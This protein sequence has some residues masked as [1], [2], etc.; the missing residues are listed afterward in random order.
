MRIGI[1]GGGVLG[2]ALAYFLSREGVETIVFEGKDKPGGLLDYFKVDGKWIDK[3]YHC[4]LSSDA[5]LLALVD[6]LGLLDRVRFTATKQ[7]VYQHGRLYSMTSGKDFLLF[8]PLSVVERIRL[9]VTIL[10]ALRVGSHRQLEEISVED[11]LVKLGGRG[12]FEKLWQPMLKAKF[13]DNYHLTPATYIWSRLKRTTSTRA[14]A[15]KQERMGYFIGSYKVFVDRLA[16]R[17]RASGSSIRL[18]AKVRQLLVSDGRVAGVQVDDE[19]VPLDAVVATTPLQIL[20]NLLP[21]Q[22]RT[23]LGLP[24]GPEFLGV[25]CGVLLLDRSL[26]PYYT[27]NIADP[28]IPFTGIIETTNLI[29]PEHVGGYHL[30]Y[31]PKYVTADSSYV[32]LSDGELRALYLDHLAR[33]FPGFS[34]SWIKHMFVF[35]ERFV[36]PLH[37]IGKPRPVVPIG[38]NLPGL[39]ILNNGQIYPDLTNCQASVR[40]ALGALPTLLARPVSGTGGAAV[41]AQPATS[42]A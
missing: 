25:V 33:M 26:T 2:M 8:P 29:A 36:E 22:Y 27:L 21:E 10:Q 9:G 38:T 24:P 6:E 4:I 13:D 35:R 14:A 20:H 18:G 40:H 11:W 39:Y 37:Q 19:N 23:G 12:T 5:E 7:G 28:E 30:A 17:I 41:R 15:G 34:E 31:L 42:G 1:V 32:Q 16:E 3:Y